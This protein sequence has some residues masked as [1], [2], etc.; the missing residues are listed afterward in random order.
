MSDD[1]FDTP[2]PTPSPKEPEPT[3]V[4]TPAPADTLLASIVNDE[5][6]QKYS[7]VESALNALKASQEHIKRL[8]GEN[9]EFRQKA[10]K[11]STMDEI[12]AAI[13]TSQVKEEPTPAEPAP[14][15]TIDEGQ[16]ANMVQGLIAQ[17][18][19]EKA[20]KANID[21]VVAAAK[22]KFGDDAT[23]AFY[24]EA[25]EKG[26]DREDINRLA[27]KNPTAVFNILGISTGKPNK[28]DL[29]ESISTSNFQQP[30]PE[31]PGR[32]M[33]YGSTKDLVSAWRDVSKRVNEKLGV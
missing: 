12:M 23:E 24:R 22:E 3:P 13:K 27:A 32:P 31:K 5:G 7:D 17:T 8:E 14:S 28:P 9:S 18:E 20:A 21:K 4:P 1:I 26:F 2:A 6:Q 15:P 16:I 29:G 10:E 19:A 25:A 33:A 30:A 11:G